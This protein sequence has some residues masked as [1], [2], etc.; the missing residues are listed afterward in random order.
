MIYAEEDVFCSAGTAAAY[1]LAAN[2]FS[3]IRDRN[4]EQRLRNASA[5]LANASF[6][7]MSWPT[8]PDQRMRTN[9]W[10]D[11]PQSVP[12]TSAAAQ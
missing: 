9:R 11:K 6:P 2:R 10:P 5:D 1:F 7:G 4:R 12:W 8:S 3:E